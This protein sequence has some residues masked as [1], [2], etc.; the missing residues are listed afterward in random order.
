MKS[1]LTTL[2][3][4]LLIALSHTVAAD[5]IVYYHNDAQGSPVAATDEN[6]DLLWSEEYE[7]YGTRL[8][9]EG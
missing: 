3:L 6:G 1:T 8:L 9:K 2:L 7:A 5:Q 4:T